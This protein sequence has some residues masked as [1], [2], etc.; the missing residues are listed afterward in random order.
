LDGEQHFQATAVLT[1]S[2][3]EEAFRVVGLPLV[4]ATL[5]GVSS[6]LLAYGGVGSGK[7]YSLVG[8]EQSHE[9]GIIVRALEMLVHLRS[10]AEINV[11]MYE[12]GVTIVCL[13][14]YALSE[15]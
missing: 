7:T 10:N 5:K 13:L 11:S 1:N 15:I 14:T 8:G 3:Q 12:V 6:T 9:T 4:E 2:S